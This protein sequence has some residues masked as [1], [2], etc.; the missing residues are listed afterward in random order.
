M[1]KNPYVSAHSK[2]KMYFPKNKISRKKNSRKFL[3]WDF[4]F[5]RIDFHRNWS[6]NYFHRKIFIKKSLKPQKLKME[7]CSSGKKNKNRKIV[8]AYLSEH[9]ASFGNKVLI[10]SLLRPV[11]NCKGVCKPFSRKSS[12]SSLS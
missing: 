4:L 10:W 12:I 5:L 2:K 9:S 7:I 3:F 8:F 1:K 6:K 11:E